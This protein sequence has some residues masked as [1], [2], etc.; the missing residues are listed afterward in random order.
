MSDTQQDFDIL[1]VPLEGVAAY[2]LS[3]KKLAGSRRNFKGMEEEAEYTNEP[4]VKHLLDIGFRGYSSERVRFL[5][6]T[7]SE[8]LLNEV[9]RRFRLMRAAVLD[10]ATGEN[11][12]RSLAKLYAQFPSPP[13]PEEKAMQLAQELV[14]LVPEHEA[15]KGRFFDVGL[16]SQDDKLVVTLLFY[17]LLSRHEGKIACQQLLKHVTSRFFRDGLAMVIDGFDTPFVRKWLKQQHDIVLDDASRK[18]RMS[19]ELC[20]AIARK[21]DYEDVYRVARSFMR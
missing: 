18:M 20:L 7:K 19:T 11:P 5:A 2:W 9:D 14:K 17:V 12:H 6:E 16:R 21:E 1:E 3:L 8:T 15:G 10:V 13:V 4:F